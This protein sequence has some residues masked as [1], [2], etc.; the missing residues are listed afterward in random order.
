M[1]RAQDLLLKAFADVPTQTAF[2]VA[3][4]TIPIL[5]GADTSKLNPCIAEASRFFNDPKLSTGSDQMMFTPAIVGAVEDAIT[6]FSTK[7][8]LT[9]E[10]FIEAYAKGL[11]AS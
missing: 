5:K 6:R 8:G 9:A 2:A 4:G 1:T 10:Q 7:G 11:S 3:N